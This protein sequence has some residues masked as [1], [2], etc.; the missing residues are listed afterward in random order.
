MAL[1]SVR[2]CVSA[3]KWL[4]LAGATSLHFR[5][6]VIFSPPTAV[7]TIGLSSV[8]A[9]WTA[10]CQVPPQQPMHQPFALS[11]LAHAHRRSSMTG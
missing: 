5:R 8:C 10:Q 7:S 11:Q 9:A 6:L 1:P 2:E 4:A 3:T